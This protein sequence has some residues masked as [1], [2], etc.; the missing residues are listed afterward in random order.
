MLVIK[1]KLV[2]LI[3]YNLQ[4]VLILFLFIPLNNFT[5]ENR[6]NLSFSFNF[7]LYGH[8][9]YR[10]LIILYLWENFTACKIN[11]LSKKLIHL[12]YVK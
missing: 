8:L 1:P 5:I 4:V 6:N 12:S 2:A 11:D 3:E 9:F 7:A 10:T